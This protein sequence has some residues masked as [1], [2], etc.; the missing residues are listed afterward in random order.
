M[1]SAPKL[2][3]LDLH[4]IGRVLVQSICTTIAGH[5]CCKVGLA[6]GNRLAEEGHIRRQVGVL[7]RTSTLTWTAHVYSDGTWAMWQGPVVGQLL[8][9]SD[10]AV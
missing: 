9:P 5:R 2:P 8:I 7:R 10:R 3:L 6:L 4:D 1:Y